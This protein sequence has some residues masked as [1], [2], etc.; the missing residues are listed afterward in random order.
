M[1]ELSAERKAAMLR[2][3]ERLAKDAVACIPTRVGVSVLVKALAT[4]MAVASRRCD[5]AK[6]LGEVKGELDALYVKEVERIKAIDERRNR[7]M[8]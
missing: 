4:W 8:N 6:L 2:E 5:D 7:R 3:A 1:S